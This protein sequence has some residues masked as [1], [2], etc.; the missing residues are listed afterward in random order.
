[1]I[2]LTGLPQEHGYRPHEPET[3]KYKFARVKDR[4]NMRHFTGHGKNNKPKFAVRSIPTGTKVRIV[5]VSRFG[6]VGITEKLDDQVGYGARVNLEELY[7][8]R[9][10]G[11]E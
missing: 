8:F 5:M 4:T 7:D 1:M 9:E 11:D 2:N 3:W 10:T 6:D